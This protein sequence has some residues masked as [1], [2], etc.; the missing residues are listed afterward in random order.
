M[1]IDAVVVSQRQV[2]TRTVCDFPHGNLPTMHYRASRRIPTK[3]AGGQQ[4]LQESS[5]VSG[6]EV[7]AASSCGQSP[8]HRP[9]VSP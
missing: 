8:F 9:D 4:V 6:R 2:K 7:S 5:V 3:T 1:D